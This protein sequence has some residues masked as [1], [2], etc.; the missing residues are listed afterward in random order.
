[1]PRQFGEHPRAHA[2]GVIGAAK[3]I[4]REQRLAARVGEKILMQRLELLRRHRI[5][6]VP[7]DLI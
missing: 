3:E 7:P 2:Q 6:V 5:V 1:M 4:L